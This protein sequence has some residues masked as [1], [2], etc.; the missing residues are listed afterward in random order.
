MIICQA[1]KRNNRRNVTR[2]RKKEEKKENTMSADN[3]N[4]TVICEEKVM[5]VIYQ[6]E[7]K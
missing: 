3:V 6:C 4:D 7:E 2:R 5:K 1:N